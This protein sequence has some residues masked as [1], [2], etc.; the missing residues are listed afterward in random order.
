MIGVTRRPRR[1][2]A[3]LSVGLTAVIAL[4]LSACGSTSTTGSASAS[5]SASGLLATVKSRGNLIMGATEG[6][7][8][9]SY[10]DPVTNQWL[11]VDADVSR[12]IAKALAVSVTA[13]PLSG[14]AQIPAVQSGRVDAMIGLFKTATRQQA[15]DYNTVPYWYVGDMVVTQ[16]TNTSLK[17]LSDLRGLTVGVVRG[18]AQ[19]I[20]AQ[21]FVTNFGVKSVQEYTDSDPMLRDV[22][23]GRLDSAIWWGFEFNWSVKQNPSLNLR[24]A[25]DVPPNYLGETQLNGTYFVFAKSPSSASLINEVDRI[26]TKMRSDGELKAI[27]AKY[28]MT[29]SS[30]L[31]GQASS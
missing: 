9:E 17:A 3:C 23:A 8:P 12:A 19:E 4:A 30:Y 10:I 28:G 26:I 6:N 29:D 1:T 5:A 13:V 22:A 18:S 25:F 31:T 21:K 11:G 20:E 7:A 2:V 24:Q 14:A 15:A 27:F 16:K